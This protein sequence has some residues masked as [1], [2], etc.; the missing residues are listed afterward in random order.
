MNKHLSPL[1]IVAALSGC[2]T[3][4]P[5]I[6][7]MGYDEKKQPLAETAIVFAPL[8]ANGLITRVALLD[9]NLVCIAGACNSGLRVV[10]GTH[11]VRFVVELPGGFVRVANTDVSIPDMKPRHVYEVQFTTS[12]DRTRVFPSIKDHG[13]NPNIKVWGADPVF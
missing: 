9:G 13:E 11:V 10:P 7:A 8:Y 6:R 2:A 5:P 4:D 3:F 1:L 12:A